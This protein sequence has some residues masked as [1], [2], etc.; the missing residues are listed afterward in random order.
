[1]HSISLFLDITKIA[2]LWW[3]NAD[4]SKSYGVC[5]VVYIFF[6]SSLGKV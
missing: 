3:K 4:L 2:D 5:H 6:E 1:M